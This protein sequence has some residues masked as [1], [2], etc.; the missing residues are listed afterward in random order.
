MCVIL[1]HIY[2]LTK[3]V[4]ST[5]PSSVQLAV[6]SSSSI[7][8]SWKPPP[9]EQQHGRLVHYHVIFMETQVHYLDDGTVI[10]AAGVEVNMTLNVTGNRAQLID[11]L[12]PSYNYAVRMAAVTNAGIGPFS[13]PVTARTL[14]DGML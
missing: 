8:L 10:L 9:L 13:A 1:A 5:S 4:P 6:Q 7:L 11:M 3:I 2:F 14:E 12:H